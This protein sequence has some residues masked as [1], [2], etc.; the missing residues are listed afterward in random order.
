MPN[1]HLMRSLG[2]MGQCTLD[3]HIAH[4]DNVSVQSGP[5]S[6][7]LAYKVHA[8]TSVPPVA[9]APFANVEIY[10]CNRKEHHFHMTM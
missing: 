6:A 8:Y 2:T 3:G 5:C 7:V 1:L 10:M 4:L 9:I